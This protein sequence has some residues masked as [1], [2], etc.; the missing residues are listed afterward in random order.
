M[1]SPA[2]AEIETIAKLLREQLPAEMVV[3]ERWGGM[4][5]STPRQ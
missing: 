1:P 2:D 5:A 3:T 4:A